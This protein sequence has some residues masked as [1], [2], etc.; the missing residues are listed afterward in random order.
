M[1]GPVSN[2]DP[3]NSGSNW[4]PVNQ[5]SKQTAQGSTV[6]G[7][8]RSKNDA[9]VKNVHEVG[10]V[11]LSGDEKKFESESLLPTPKKKFF[12]TL[13]DG[14]AHRFNSVKN[15]VA[16]R[17][18]SIAHSVS[19][20]GKKPSVSAERAEAL[21]DKN[22]LPSLT[23]FPLKEIISSLIAIVEEKGGF[24]QEGIFRLSGD[25]SKAE[26]F[27]NEM[28]KTVP[29][30]MKDKSLT[31][32]DAVSLI[33]HYAAQARVGF[34]EKNDG[35]MNAMLESGLDK[36]EILS[37]YEQ[38]DGEDRELLETVLTCASRT[39]E[40]KSTTKMG[41]VNLSMVFAP[42]LFPNGKI[43]PL[44]LIQHNS[45]SLKASQALI[46]VFSEKRLSQNKF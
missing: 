1:N 7:V 25:H 28:L 31:P 42:I 45:L 29:Q 46:E 37:L 34:S 36:N 20:I 17:F 41:A 15:A 24:E 4:T 22:T 44:N 8:S 9:Q 16:S 23:F 38:I 32:D 11:L 10:T 13:K 27:K 21:S 2:P 5:P 30:S 6:P 3:S 18:S 14:I 39:L 26:I 12:K 19:N 33:K 35:L 43:D 40:N